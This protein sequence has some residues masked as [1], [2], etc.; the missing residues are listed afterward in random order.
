MCIVKYTVYLI[1]FQ[2]NLQKRACPQLA[3]ANLG[4]PCLI[5][6]AMT[7]KCEREFSELR[8]IFYATIT[9]CVFIYLL[10]CFIFGFMVVCLSMGSW[11]LLQ[12]ILMS[13]NFF[14]P[15]LYFCIL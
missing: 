7:Y 14:L 8:D 4:G 5:C 1:N 9:F 12:T 13:L 3:K 11:T 15:L 2:L 10:V 6:H